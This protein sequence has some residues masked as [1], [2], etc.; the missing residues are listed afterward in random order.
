MVFAEDWSG[1]LLKLSRHSIE[2]GGLESELRM[3]P[4]KPATGLVASVMV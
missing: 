4:G 1:K 3:I 2:A